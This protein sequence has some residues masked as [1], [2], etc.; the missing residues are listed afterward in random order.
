MGNPNHDSKTGEFSAGGGSD[1]AAGHH[2]APAVNA[3]I[4]DAN[5]RFEASKK[6]P[7]I[8]RVAQRIE[9]AYVAMQ[10]SMMNIAGISRSDASKAIETLKQVKAIKVNIRSGKFDVKHGAFME[11][12]VIRRAVGGLKK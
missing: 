9:N 11:P 10:D 12:D 3:A 6:L 4:A 8:E 5:V 1:K 2:V 7:G